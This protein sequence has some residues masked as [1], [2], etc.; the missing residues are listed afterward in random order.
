VPLRDLFRV[1]LGVQ[2]INVD[3]SRWARPHP[4]AAGFAVRRTLCT[5]QP[6]TRYDRP[7]SGK[8]TIY[9]W[10][11]F[12]DYTTVYPVTKNGGYHILINRLLKASNQGV[13][14]GEEAG[15]SP[16]SFRGCDRGHA[17][18]MILI[19]PPLTIDLEHIHELI[20]IADKTFTK[21]EEEIKI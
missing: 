14:N 12:R 21:I 19:G 8:K 11:L 4:A 3:F 16:S 2:F 15:P 7:P 9:G 1:L 5:P 10:A 18:D 17:G 6:E 13:R 20:S